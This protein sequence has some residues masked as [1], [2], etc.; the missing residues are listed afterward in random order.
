[1][2]C[3]LTLSRI[4]ND[5][6]YSKDAETRCVVK[7]KCPHTRQIPKAAIIVKT[8]DQSQDVKIEG[9]NKR[10]LSQGAYEIRKLYHLPF[11]RYGQSSIFKK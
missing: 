5:L 11:N 1:M 6:P 4:I 2:S 7:H 8:Q 10:V 3:E 9:T